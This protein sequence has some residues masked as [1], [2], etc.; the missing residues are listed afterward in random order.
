MEPPH[1][2]SLSL[3]DWA[4]ILALACLAWFLLTRNFR[5][6]DELARTV[7]GLAEELGKFRADMA[8]R[9]VQKADQAREID[10]LE[11]SIAD[12][13][14]RWR[15]DLARHRD[16]CPDRRRPIPGGLQGDRG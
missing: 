3:F 9:Y 16:D 10:R 8:E 5:A 14:E 15:E 4:T 1:P 11:Q 13:A 6:Q 7:R 2:L 12:H